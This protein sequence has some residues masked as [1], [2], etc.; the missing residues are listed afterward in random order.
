MTP[1]AG[2]WQAE[3]LDRGLISVRSGSNN[4]VQWRLLG[5]EAASTGFN[6][7]RDGTRVAGPITDSTNYLDSGA[8]AG[9][10]YTVRAVVERRPSRRRRRRR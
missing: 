4:L 7:Y 9:A 6:V 10:R 5:T 1:P 8:S 3:K 2:A